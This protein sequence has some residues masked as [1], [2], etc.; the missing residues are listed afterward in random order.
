MKNVFFLKVKKY[1]Q[2]VWSG[3]SISSQNY[4]DGKTNQGKF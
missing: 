1:F 4:L 3:I 2:D